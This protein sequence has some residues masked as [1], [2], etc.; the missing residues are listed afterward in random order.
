MTK[1]LMHVS[2]QNPEAASLPIAFAKFV[3]Q[4]PHPSTGPTWSGQGLFL[5]WFASF[6]NCS[7]CSHTSSAVCLLLTMSMSCDNS[8]ALSLAW[9]AMPFMKSVMGAFQFG[10]GFGLGCGLGLGL[11]AGVGFGFGFG[12]GFGLPMVAKPT[13]NFQ[14]GRWQLGAFR[15]NSRT[16]RPL[17]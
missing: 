5:H 15:R 14:S 2:P 1:N 13:A 6:T 12:C 9:Q 8:W 7:Q 11:G 4:S 10:S 16:R 3:Q 17:H